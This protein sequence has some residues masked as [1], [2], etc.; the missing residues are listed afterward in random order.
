MS[1]GLRSIWSKCP[2]C[3]VVR[4]LPGREKEKKE[5][6]KKKKNGKPYVTA[7]TERRPPLDPLPSVEGGVV[8]H[9]LLHVLASKRANRLC[10]LCTRDIAER[11]MIAA[12]VF[13]PEVEAM[14]VCLHVYPV[15]SAHVQLFF[16]PR[17]CSR[18]LPHSLLPLS[19]RTRLSVLKE[20]ARSARAIIATA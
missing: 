18:F 15:L 10:V 13:N 9:A 7:C 14:D 20:S 16:V 4:L 19:S 6:K 11:D 17:A 1:C 5:K 8:P 2:Y 3:A 12:S